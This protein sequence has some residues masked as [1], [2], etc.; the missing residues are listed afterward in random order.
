MSLPKVT[1]QSLRVGTRVEYYI[2][3]V[4]EQG[5]VLQSLGT[6]DRPFAFTVREERPLYQKWWFW[7]IAGAVVV[8]TT[9]ALVTTREGPFQDGPKVMLPARQ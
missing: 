4:D 2:E 1:T 8:G 7:T 3:A 6:E 5:G 9:T